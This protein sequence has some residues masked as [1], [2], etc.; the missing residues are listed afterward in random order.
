MTI[1]IGDKVKWLRKPATVVAI[2]PMAFAA[3]TLKDENGY[4]WYLLNHD[5]N[6]FIRENTD[7][8]KP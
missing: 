4:E 1:E 6:A 8:A 5:L 7:E 2:E 3:L